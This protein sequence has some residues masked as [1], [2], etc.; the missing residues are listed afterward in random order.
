MYSP[1]RCGLINRIPRSSSDN[2]RS[3]QSI[4]TGIALRDIEAIPDS[5]TTGK[6]KIRFNVP[7][8]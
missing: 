7:F 1:V 4:E 8:D 6:Y 5:L 2:R 3:A